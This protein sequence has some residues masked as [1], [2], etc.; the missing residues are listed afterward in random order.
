MSKFTGPTQLIIR[1]EHLLDIIPAG[2]DE[3]QINRQT[4]HDA[5]VTLK[6][7]ATFMRESRS[8]FGNNVVSAHNDRDSIERMVKSLEAMDK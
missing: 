4:I 5:I 2:N 7:Y 8:K 1:L 6:A 3:Q